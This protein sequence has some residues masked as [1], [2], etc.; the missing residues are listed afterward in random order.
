MQVMTNRFK[1]LMVK[2]SL[3]GLVAL[4][5][6]IR[7]LATIYLQSSERVSQAIYLYALNASAVIIASYLGLFIIPINIR[8]GENK[9]NKYSALRI[10][11][12]ILSL[13]CSSVILLILFSL[14]T[15][16]NS[17]SNSILREAVTAISFANF[18]LIAAYQKIN[19]YIVDM[20]LGRI[21]TTSL[22]VLLVVWIIRFDAGETVIYL[23]LN[24]T[25]VLPTLYYISKYKIFMRPKL[26]E[27]MLYVYFSKFFWYVLKYRNFILMTIFF[28]FY[29]NMDRLMIVSNASK[30]YSLQYAQATTVFSIIIVLYNL[31]IAKI[32][33]K[34]LGRQEIIQFKSYLINGAILM[35]ALYFVIALFFLIYVKLYL[36]E[37]ML[38][39]IDQMGIILFHYTAYAISNFVFTY[40]EPYGR[41]FYIKLLLLVGIAA[42]YQYFMQK[43]SVFAIPFIDCIL[44]LACAYIIG[45]NKSKK[46]Y[47]PDKRY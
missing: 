17:E 33:S 18:G 10:E 3:Y 9:R 39:R 38:S 11:A 21:I 24:L 36:Q 25:S 22:Y 7:F 46:I 44:L 27:K 26:I 14:L 1:T 31:E 13:A 30:I 32:Y 34:I 20:L 19:N 2:H 28:T 40:F 15:S 6:S 37:N 47:L 5:L 45:V 43:Y 41:L 42:L 4:D 35:S 12:T 8:Y 29:L 16:S 23:I